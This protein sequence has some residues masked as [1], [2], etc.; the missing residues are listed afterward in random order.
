MY[1]DESVDAGGG[2]LIVKMAKGHQ[3]INKQERK[4]KKIVD[5]DEVELVKKAWE[6]SRNAGWVQKW[7]CPTSTSHTPHISLHVVF[8]HR[9]EV[10]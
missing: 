1:N 2:N 3:K 10:L 5:W 8:T 6:H 7:Q 4:N 9:L